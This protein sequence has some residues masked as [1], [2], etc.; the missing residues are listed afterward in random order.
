MLNIKENIEEIVKT[1]PEGVRLIAV[2]KTK[3]VEYIEEAYAGGQ[4]AFGENRPQEMAAKYRQLPKDIE[5]HMIGQLQEKNVKYI[6]SFIAQC[7]NGY[8]G[9]TRI[10][11]TEECQWTRS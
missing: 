4:R 8:Y 10:P 5:W 3:P 6:A 7:D 2:S 11:N 1:L 9:I